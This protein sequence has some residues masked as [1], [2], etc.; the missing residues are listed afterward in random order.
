MTYTRSSLNPATVAHNTTDP[1]LPSIPDDITI[2]Q[3]LLDSVH[4]TSIRPSRPAG[5]PWLVEDETGREVDL[6]EVG[7]IS[8]L[9]FWTVAFPC[10][11]FFVPTALLFR[12]GVNAD[13]V[14]Y[15]S[16]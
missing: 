9:F 14:I 8:F 1:S 16:E 7:S 5:S 15:G 12:G 3:L 11:S 6:A 2:T 4:I 13:S 10:L